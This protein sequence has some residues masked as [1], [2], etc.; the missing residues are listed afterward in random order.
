MSQQT[1]SR[2]SR[3]AALFVAAAALLAPA[4]AQAGSPEPF[5]PNNVESTEHETPGAVVVTT[6][7]S[8]DTV[9]AWYRAHLKDK[10][11]E[12]KHAQ[13]IFFFTKSGATVVITPAS[14]FQDT[15]AG[16]QWDAKKYGPDTGK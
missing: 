6:K 2:Q 10:T 4:L 7:D 9:A 1:L 15:M 3:R 14:R 16:V 5:Y 8:G 11:D 12:Q 13:S